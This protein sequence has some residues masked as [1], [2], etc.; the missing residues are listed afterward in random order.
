MVIAE[1]K[2]VNL[3]QRYG[4][5]KA[6]ELVNLLLDEYKLSVD[7]SDVNSV[8]YR[9][10][11]R[12]KLKIDDKYRWTMATSSQTSRMATNKQDLKKNRSKKKPCNDGS[13][14]GTKLQNG[15]SANPI[16]NQRSWSDYAS[17]RLTSKSK[18]FSEKIINV[19]EPT[20][21]S[22]QLSS[23][24][25]PSDSRSIVKSIFDKNYMT[26]GRR[27]S[28]SF[29]DK[30][31]GPESI[32]FSKE[33][34]QIIDL[35]SSDNL[36]IRGQPGCGKTT[37][38]AARAEKLV[39]EVHNGSVLF[40]T[41]NAALC[42]YV[43]EIFKKAKL[44]NDI[45]IMTFH[46]WSK[47]LAIKLGIEFTGWVDGK[48]RIIKLTKFISEA[49]GSLG[50]H[51][52]YSLEKDHTLIDWWVAELCWLFG[53][54]ITTLDIYIESERI[55]RGT[56]VRVTQEDK[57][58]VWFVYEAYCDWLKETY[59]EDY[60]NPAGLVQR[61]IQHHNGVIPD[62][63]KYDYTMV[64]EVQDFDRS[65]L[66]VA[67][68]ATRL[69]ICMAGDLAQKIYRRNFTWKSVG[70][71][72]NGGRSRQLA[73]S[74]RTTQ[75]IMRVSQYLQE[76]NNED[77]A[78]G[79]STIEWP[80]KIGEP[81]ALLHGTNPKQAYEQGYDWVAKKFKRMRTTT[82]AVVLPFTRQLYPAQ[83][84]LEQRGVKAKLAKGAV[85]G[86]FDGGVVVTTY[87]Q[88]KGLEF[89][90]VVM[91][92]LH[93]KQYPLRFLDS[94]AE[95]YRDTE[96]QILKRVLYMTMT[97]ARQTVTL[98]GSTPF[99]RYFEDIPDELFALQES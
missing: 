47:R 5:V 44:K 7:K 36:L 50:N 61:A 38:L 14:H 17:A 63:A 23:D 34:Q 51:R 68:M 72:I 41:Y 12:K 58:F 60:D 86:R 3:V 83:K 67:S 66:L 75:Q 6:R 45:E 11:A 26:A 10:K 95:E 52:L 37:I 59:Q 32:Q 49:Q 24:I 40:L 81:V 16:H 85:L 2:I 73:A 98:V 96:N 89:D 78:S 42:S 33:Q 57:R 56:D 90:H 54:S 27:I 64:D 22:H 65:W 92:G 30:L 48:E 46:D 91:L 69:S 97:R 76:G 28:R 71:R 29:I 70:I 84:A 93:D 18:N 39:G 35:D 94:I 82:V 13:E 77:D 55:N 15:N 9:M 21:S 99:C 1:Q 20:S 62:Y 25:T 43:S 31:F 80:K 19:S 53:Q 88:L 4:P 8:L 79:L 74:Y 87:H